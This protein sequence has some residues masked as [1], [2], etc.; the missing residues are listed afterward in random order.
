MPA[1]PYVLTVEPSHDNSTVVAVS[2]DVDKLKAFAQSLTRHRLGWLEWS[3]GF[4]AYIDSGDYYRIV[5]APSE[6]L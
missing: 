1:T 5:R 2:D 6:V 3:G 4:D